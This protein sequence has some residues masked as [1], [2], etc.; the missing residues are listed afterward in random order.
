MALNLEENKVLER[1]P[2]LKLACLKLEQMARDLGPEAKLP[3]MLELRSQLG[4]SLRTINDAVRELERGGILSSINGVG[5]Y[6]A[7]PFQ[8]RK[9]GKLGLLFRAFYFNHPYTAELLTGVRREAA[10]Q[11][12]EVVLLDEETETLESGKVDALLMYCHMTEALLMQLPEDL[13][14]VLLFQHSPDFTCVVPDDFEGSK[15]ATRHL[16]D[17]GHRRI[18]CMPS[19]MQDSISRQRLAGYQAA[20]EEAGIAVRNDLVKPLQRT[21]ARNYRDEGEQAM[22]GWLKEDWRDLD[23]TAIVAHNDETAI[24]IIRVLNETG[25]RVPE[26]VSVVGFDGTEI[27]A[28]CTPRL[29]TVKVPLEEIGARVVK[30]LSEQIRDGVSEIEKITLPVQLKLGESTAPRRL[31]EVDKT[32]RCV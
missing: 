5:V 10:R 29:S 23:C 1:R 15:I 17:L 25:L 21:S 8:V 28:L 30:V 20:L 32:L 14:R 13:P 26:D 4:M 6:V 22:A 7:N 9:T 11:N 2:R 18:A 24:S 31:S 16:L 12:L 3:T 27:S 19:S